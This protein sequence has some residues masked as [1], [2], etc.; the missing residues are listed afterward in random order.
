MTRTLRVVLDTNVLISGI[1]YPRST[2]G[3]ILNAWRSGRIAAVFSQ[4]MLD[5]AARV[6]PRFAKSSAELRDV[7]EW[8]A[9]LPFF[10]EVVEPSPISAGLVRDPADAP[11]LGTLLAAAADYLGTGDKDLPALAPAYPI[12]TP[13]QFWFRHG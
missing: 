6:L 11:V 9:L 4:H 10:G 3:A 12:L 5:E 7:E 13:A 8:L 2:P 1:A